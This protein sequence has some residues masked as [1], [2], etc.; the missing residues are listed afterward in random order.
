M[1]QASSTLVGVFILGAATLV[2]AAV[3]FFGSG[4]LLKQRIAMVSYFPGSVAGLQTGAPVTAT[5]AVRV[6]AVGAAVYGAD[7]VGRG[8]VSVDSAGPRGGSSRPSAVV[9]DSVV[10]ADRKGDELP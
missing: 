10:G 5:E 8:A 3:I 2:F 9:V 7:A 4:K 6:V 1:R